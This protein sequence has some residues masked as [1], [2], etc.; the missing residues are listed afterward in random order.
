MNLKQRTTRP[1][2]KPTEAEQELSRSRA[3][4]LALLEETLALDA[5]GASI[6][7]RR[8]PFPMAHD[9]RKTAQQLLEP[10]LGRTTALPSRAQFQKLAPWRL[11]LERAAYRCAAVASAVADERR[12]QL[13]VGQSGTHPR[14]VATFEPYWSLIHSIGHLTLFAC[15]RGVRQW[16]AEMASTFPWV[17]WTPSFPLTRERTLWLSL[18][19]ARAA[20]AFGPDVVDSY[21]GALAAA[22]H[23]FKTF[24]ALLG[25]T[26]IGLAH[27]SVLKQITQEV[28][29]S[30]ASLSSRK[31]DHTQLHEL[32][33]ISALGVLEN[34]RSTVV[35]DFEKSLGWDESPTV[36]LATVATF[37][38]DPATCLSSGDFA[39]LLCVPVAVETEPADF[40]EICSS[41][42]VTDAEITAHLRRVST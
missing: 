7:A 3:D 5:K 21:L 1:V 22:I 36:G 42:I 31:T 25:L 8:A 28:R 15:G 2:E 40:Y 16:M 13:L 35:T 32:A 29:R 26:S 33:F 38:T 12:R 4:L 19:G 34:P 24:D 39:G 6:E 18:C 27:H 14:A 23:P 9:A 11:Q 17:R 10:F 20:A 37:M 41:A 30:L